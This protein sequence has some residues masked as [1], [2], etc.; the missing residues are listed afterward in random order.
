[1]V[2]HNPKRVMD[3]INSFLPLKPDSVSPPEMYLGTKLKKKTLHLPCKL[4]MNPHLTG[5][6]AGSSRGETVLS[7]WL[8]VEAL[9]T[10]N[11]PTS[12]GLRF[13]RQWRSHTP[14]IAPLVLPFG[15]MQLTRR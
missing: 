5:G 6:S 8:S 12:T 3:K 14:S 7:P 11:A 15:V 2:H 10:S 4:L 9:D 13:P 1:V